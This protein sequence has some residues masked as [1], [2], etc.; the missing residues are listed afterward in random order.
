MV[1]DA[2]KKSRFYFIMRNGSGKGRNVIFV[3]AIYFERSFVLE[4]LLNV[5]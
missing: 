2:V 3:D 4:D 5:L 1:V